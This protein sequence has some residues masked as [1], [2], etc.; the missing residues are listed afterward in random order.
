MIPSQS[1]PPTTEALARAELEAEV[2]RPT[3]GP[4]VSR[5]YISPTDRFFIEGPNGERIATSLRSGR[6]NAQLMDA[7]P[8]LLERAYA[9][10]DEMGRT[11]D[12]LEHAGHRGLA[13]RMRQEVEYLR[14]AIAKAPPM[15]SP[16]PA[17]TAVAKR[18]L[19]ELKDQK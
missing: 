5:E 9:A 4:W 2:A 18:L 16:L 3:D 7:A 14:A 12:L 15:T 13:A 6:A 19:A 8:D 10:R 1:D 11:A 17:Q